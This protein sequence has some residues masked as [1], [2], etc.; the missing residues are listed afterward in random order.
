MIVSRD[1]LIFSYSKDKN[2]VLESKC[3]FLLEWFEKIKKKNNCVNLLIDK[4]LLPNNGTQSSD[5]F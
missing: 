2:A 5:V 1:T 3:G 4:V